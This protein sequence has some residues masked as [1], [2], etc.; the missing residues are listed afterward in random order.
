MPLF[1]LKYLKFFKRFIDLFKLKW[2]SI[3][4]ALCLNLEEGGKKH[5]RIKK[6][7]AGI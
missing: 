2:Y 3:Y 1:I 4:R 6:C 7:H 5:G